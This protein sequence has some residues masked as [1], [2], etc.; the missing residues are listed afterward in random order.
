MGPYALGE[1]PEVSAALADRL[2]ATGRSGRNGRRS[3]IARFSAVE[4][5]A[6]RASHRLGDRVTGAYT[7]EYIICKYGSL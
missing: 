3:V 6:G 2:D 5:H 4:A 1:G 7:Y